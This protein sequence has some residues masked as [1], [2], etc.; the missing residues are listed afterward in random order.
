VSTGAT[1]VLST[2]TL[3]ASALGG[4]LAGVLCDRSA[5]PRR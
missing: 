1:G 4:V 5:G 3:S 2:V